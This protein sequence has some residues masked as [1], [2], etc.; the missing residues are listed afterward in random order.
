MSETRL[1]VYD[2]ET[3]LDVFGREPQV[4]DV[5]PAYR[6]NGPREGERMGSALVRRITGDGPEL[7]VRFEEVE[8]GVWPCL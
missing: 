7:E 3:H 2:R 6:G 1:T 4:G 8:R 5:I